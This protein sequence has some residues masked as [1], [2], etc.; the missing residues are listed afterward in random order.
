MRLA[1]IRRVLPFWKSTLKL[2]DWT[3]SVRHGTAAEM[4][5]TVG[6]NFIHPEEMKSEILLRRG[7]SEETLI[8][9]LL[10]IVFDGDKPQDGKYDVLHE[11]A[12]NRTAGALLAMKGRE[13]W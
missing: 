5:D 3:I 2:E 8:H 12:I 10:H 4:V 13:P 7:E 9:E 1:E 6:L 11:R